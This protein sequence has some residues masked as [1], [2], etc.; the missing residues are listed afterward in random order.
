MESVLVQGFFPE[1]DRSARPREERRV[2]MREMG[3]VYSSDPAVTHHLAQF[4][5]EQ[6][7]PET[8]GPSTRPTAVLFNGGVMKAEPLRRGV[9][10]I[11]SHWFSVTGDTP[12]R[13]IESQ[14]FDL[15][16]SKGAVYY[17]LA[18]RGKGVRIRGGLPKS[19]YIGIEAALPSVPGMPTP[20]KALCVAPYGMEEGTEA[21]IADREF[22]L[23]V[24]EPVKFDFLGSNT[25]KQDALGM[26]IDDWEGDIEEI[27]HLETNLEGETG[28]VVPV[29]LQIKVTEVGTLEVWCIARGTHQRHKLEFNVRERKQ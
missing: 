21:D 8:D 7:V 13:E 1:C 28:R 14:D 4:L 15:A 11:L 20:L 29:T 26:V 22:G 5:S 19:Y 10:Q 23:V 18:R 24:G 27:T 25:R 3:L 12:V 6:T 17:G 16:V 2:G 9:I